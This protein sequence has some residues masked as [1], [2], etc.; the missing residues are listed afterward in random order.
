MTMEDLPHGGLKVGDLVT[1]AGERCRVTSTYEGCDEIVI[2]Q[3]D[4]PGG[5]DVL[6]WDVRRVEV[7][8]TA[9]G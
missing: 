6:W 7:T 5:F 2:E 9:P 8:L 4:E 3:L 1:W